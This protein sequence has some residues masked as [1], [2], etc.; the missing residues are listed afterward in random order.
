MKFLFNRITDNLLT[1][2][3]DGNLLRQCIRDD[4]MTTQHSLYRSTY[5]TS[6]AVDSSVSWFTD[7]VS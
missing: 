1:T 5:T 7:A 2:R 4:S 3:G 6:S